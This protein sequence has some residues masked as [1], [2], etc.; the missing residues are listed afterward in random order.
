VSIET[1]QQGVEDGMKQADYER[2]LRVGYEQADGEW[3][4]VEPERNVTANEGIP[5]DEPSLYHFLGADADD[6]DP[7]ELPTSLDLRIIA[8]DH[9]TDMVKFAAE[10]GLDLPES[11]TTMA[12]ASAYFL[13]TGRPYPPDAPRVFNSDI[14]L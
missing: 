2:G 9:A 8:L 13:E 10:Q 1:Y 7:V 5:A 12:A 4:S 11:V 14:G 3:N 6:V